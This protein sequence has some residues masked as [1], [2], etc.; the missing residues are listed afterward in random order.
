MPL[1]SRPRPILNQPLD[2]IRA[3]DILPESLLLQQLQVTQR[4]PRICQVFEVW[5][6]APVLQVGEV[7]DKRGLGEEF[8][9][10]EVVE[11]EWVCEGLNKLRA[12]QYCSSVDFI[13]RAA[14]TAIF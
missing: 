14:A 7:G 6:P 9:R 10:R 1:H 8:L 3:H 4:W 12:S 2:K 13:Q 11:V 5:R